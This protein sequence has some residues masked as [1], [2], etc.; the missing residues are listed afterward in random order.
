MILGKIPELFGNEQIGL[1]AMA[2]YYEY[3]YAHRKDE[4]SYKVGVKSSAGQEDTLFNLL[5][6]NSQ[7]VKAYKRINNQNDPILDFRQSFQTAAKA[8]QVI[9]SPTRG[10]VVQYKKKGIEDS[11]ENGEEIVKRPVWHG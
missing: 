10:V 1:E 4:M 2:K 7:A 3:Y 9:D 6:I 8:F 11:E 5:S